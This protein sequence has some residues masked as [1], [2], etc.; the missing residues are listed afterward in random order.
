MNETRSSPPGA[1]GT[2]STSSRRSFLGTGALIGAGA[3]GASFVADAAASEESAA[4]AGGPLT[5]GDIAILRFLAAAEIIEAD[6]WIQ[7]NELG[8]IQNSEVP[9]GSG[10]P[11][12]TEALAVLDEDM[13]QYIH[14]NTE[15]EITHAK[16]LNAYLVSKGADP[17]TLDSFRHLPSS[18]AT[19]ARN[20]GRLTNL[21]ELTV[22]T[23]WWTRYRADSHN[24]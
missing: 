8:G 9:G 22:D 13:D 24:P 11:T 4:A 1:H 3:L 23:T 6:L 21:M 5:R 12:Y 17:V 2:R 7:Y 15:D 19:G 14:D 18:R 20:L 10:N 16:F